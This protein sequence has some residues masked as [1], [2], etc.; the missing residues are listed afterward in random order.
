[1]KHTKASK[2]LATDEDDLDKVGEGEDDYPEEGQGPTQNDIVSK[3]ICMPRAI[4][5]F[6]EVE[7]HKGSIASRLG[8]FR[9]LA[10]IFSIGTMCLFMWA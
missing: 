6:S 9:G 8:N 4:F 7:G 5:D 10:F 2:P 3:F 1:M